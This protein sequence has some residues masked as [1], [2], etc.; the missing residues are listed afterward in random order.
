MATA[1]IMLYYH[2]NY[3][4]GDMDTS[5]GCRFLLAFNNYIT[6]KKGKHVGQGHN[7]VW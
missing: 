4:S 6:D 5:S 7:A 2:D 1:D 3:R